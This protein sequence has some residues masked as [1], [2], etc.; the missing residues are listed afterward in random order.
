M[1]TLKSAKPAIVLSIILPI[2][3]FA[4]ALVQPG[5]GTLLATNG[6]IFATPTILL[7]GWWAGVLVKK[8]K[9][10]YIDAGIGGLA[11]GVAHGIVAIALFGYVAGGS[12]TQLLDMNI[13]E[14]IV[15]VAGAVAGSGIIV[16][17][18]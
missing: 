3:A 18:K 11:V 13:I 16:G 17:G 1:K 10:S 5:V 12:I 4:V 8:S 9:G 14:T 7:I 2:L 6:L 15:A